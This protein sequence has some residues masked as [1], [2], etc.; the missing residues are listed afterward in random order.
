MTETGVLRPCVC[1]TQARLRPEFRYRVLVVHKHDGDRSFE[2]VCWF[3]VHKQDRDRSFETMCWL[4]TRMTETGVSRPCV[5]CTQARRRPEFR[6]RVLVCCTQNSNSCRTTASSILRTRRWSP[7]TRT[8]DGLCSTR[9]TSR[10]TSRPLPTKRPS[11]LWHTVLSLSL[12]LSVRKC[13]DFVFRLWQ[14]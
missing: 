11:G 7:T 12:S 1:R 4:Y 9:L 6:D 8:T 3:V 2:T 14:Q 5:G 10:Q 13:S